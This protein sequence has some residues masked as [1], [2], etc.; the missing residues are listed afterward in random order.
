[1]ATLT[2]L[3]THVVAWIA[4]GHHDRLSPAAV[5]AI[6]HDTLRVSPLVPLELQYL[7]ETG[8]LELDPDETMAELRRSLDLR[9]AAESFGSV[10]DTAVG[11]IWTRDPFDRLIAAQAITADARLLTK[12]DHLLDHVDGAFWDAP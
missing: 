1:M 4:G 7:V 8:R 12:D 2:H 5:A 10:V 6:E 3:D 11:L 9:E